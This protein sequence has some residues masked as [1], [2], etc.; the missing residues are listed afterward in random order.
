MRCFVLVAALMGL[1]ACGGEM[2]PEET[3]APASTQEAAPAQVTAPGSEQVGSESLCTGGMD[4]YCAQF[5]TE[6]TCPAAS[7]CIWFQSRCQFA[8]E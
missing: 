1:T 5:K 6:A 4:C 2:L 3:Q 8:Y 7:H